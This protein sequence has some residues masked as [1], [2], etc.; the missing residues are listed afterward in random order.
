MGSKRYFVAFSRQGEAATPSLSMEMSLNASAGT[1]PLTEMAVF[2][3]AFF[4]LALCDGSKLPRVSS[5]FEP[6]ASGQ[7]RARLSA[8]E[9]T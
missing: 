5:P 1:P 9:T 6:F 8:T 4:V 3:H 2:E 7:R